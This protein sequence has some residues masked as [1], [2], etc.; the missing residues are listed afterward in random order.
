MSD[1]VLQPHLR[2]S[3]EFDG[4]ATMSRLLF[5][6]ILLLSLL[7]WSKIAFF[8]THRDTI[9]YFFS[10]SPCWSRRTNTIMVK[11]R[12]VHKV[13]TMIT[14][15]SMTHWWNYYNNSGVWIWG[16]LSCYTKWTYYQMLLPLPLLLDILTKLQTMSLHILGLQR[17]FMEPIM[18]T[19]QPV[20]EAKYSVCTH[21][22]MLNKLGLLCLLRGFQ[23]V[24]TCVSERSLKQG[25]NGCPLLT[26]PQCY[27][28][29]LCNT[30]QWLH[31]LSQIPHKETT[32]REQLNLQMKVSP[33]PWRYTVSTRKS[34]MHLVVQV[35]HWNYWYQNNG[36]CGWWYGHIFQLRTAHI[37][38]TYY[39]MFLPKQR[40]HSLVTRSL[41]L[42]G[43]C[44][45]SITPGTTI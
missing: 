29:L 12:Q 32:A 20:V 11:K 2:W 45:W 28:A 17:N 7:L 5:V 40:T 3:R 42:S 1:V 31:H 15:T 38:L 21:C 22:I 4:Y 39:L 19:H 6:L 9:I 24:C 43:M 44:A 23:Y 27:T 10:L 41:L 37:A 34:R 16:I 8:H 25:L 18:D 36:A 14:I 35:S 13:I 33:F 30:I 26:T